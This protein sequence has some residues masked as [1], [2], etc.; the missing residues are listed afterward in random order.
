MALTAPGPGGLEVYRNK[1]RIKLYDETQDPSDPNERARAIYHA[2][3]R[4]R[5]VEVD[6]RE[7]MQH[8]ETRLTI[9][10]VAV[11][12]FEPEVKA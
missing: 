2:G 3:E 11:N 12:E 1:K 10:V 8:I 4:W 6:G 5:R 7:H 9:R